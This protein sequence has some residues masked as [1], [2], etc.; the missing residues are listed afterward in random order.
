MKLTGYYLDYGCGSGQL[1]EIVIKQNSLI[2]YGLDY[3]ENSVQEV[4]KKIKSNNWKGASLL[5][6]FPS[7]YES[8]FFDIVTFI[9]TIEHLQDDI[10]TQTILEIKRVIKT[11]GKVIVTTPFNEDLSKHNVFCPFCKSEFHHMQHMQTFNKESISKL[12]ILKGFEIEYCDN[13]NLQ[14]Y[15]SFNDRIKYIVGRYL[16]KRINDNKPHLVLVASKL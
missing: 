7:S 8:D 16:L 10:L 3:S 9:E 1:L 15:N 4:N 2:C 6:S 11:N 12:F 14:S 13:I 5:R